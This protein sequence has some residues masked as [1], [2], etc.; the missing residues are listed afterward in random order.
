MH[1]K[2]D[3][4]YLCMF[5]VTT[6]VNLQGYLRWH[7]TWGFP[8]AKKMTLSKKIEKC[9][10][11]LVYCCVV[12]NNIP[13]LIVTGRC[14]EGMLCSLSINNPTWLI[15]LPNEAHLG[16]AHSRNICSIHLA[17]SNQILA[18][19]PSSIGLRIFLVSGVSHSRVWKSI[20][21]QL[22]ENK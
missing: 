2:H 19:I 7:H 16:L 20:N 14:R 18:E 3:E 22:L 5:C 17:L 10:C 21:R 9:T 1:I 8:T 13:T 6:F 15:R 11:K 4:T 12:S